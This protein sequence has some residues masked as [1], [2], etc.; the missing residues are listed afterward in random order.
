MLCVANFFF[1]KKS[2]LSINSIFRWFIV[3]TFGLFNV[4]WAQFS[5]LP[6]HWLF[7]S[8]RD[9]NILKSDTTL[10]TNVYPL[11][12]FV[13]QAFSNV[14]TNY[15]MFK[16]IKNDPALDIMFEKDVVS[17]RKNNF[18]IRINPLINFQKGKV[19]GDTSFSAYTNTRG[20]I[21]SVQFDRVYIET[22]LSENQSVF[23]TYLYQYS[24][25][26][27]VVPG[28]GR[29]K[30]FKGSGFDYAFSAGIVSVQATKNLNITL[31]TGKQKIG[32][33]YRSLLLSDN[34]FVYPYIKFEQ[35]WWK[36]RLQYICNYAMLNNLVSASRSIPKNTERLFQ[37]KIFVYHYLNVGITKHTRV[38]F[39]QSI[40]SET[41]D[42]R[43]VWRGDGIVFS[44]VIFTQLAYYGLNQQNNVMI[45]MDM[46]Q[47][48]L[49]NVVIYGQVILDN[50]SIFH[51]QD[52][53]YGYQLGFKWLGKWQDWRIMLLSEWNDVR[54]NIGFSVWPTIP[55]YTPPVVNPGSSYTHFG[56]SMNYTPEVGNELVSMLAIKKKRWITA[57]QINSQD[58]DMARVLYTKFLFGFV[59]NSSYNLLINLG[60]ENRQ[61]FNQN[62]NYIYL[63]LQTALYNIFY[64]F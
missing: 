17:I 49:K 29:W 48:L 28:Q 7:Q 31:G 45:G 18:H 14:D 13:Y 26:T 62:S 12:P 10:P 36:G 22:M 50:D 3:F 19:S 64:D 11:N 52:G 57:F 56:Q 21:A 8:I 24:K 63:Q 34:A 1:F 38:G 54:K 37:K 9:Y 35:L 61:A 33:G 25:S 46:Q 55:S 15:R 16:Y 51:N 5:S 23:P 6:N 30:T 39:F 44:P 43:N 32:N 20:F 42:D 40:V 4:L 47:K 27:G 41:P 60:I 53:G 58:N 59:L 2:I